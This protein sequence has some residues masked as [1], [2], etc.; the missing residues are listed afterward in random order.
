MSRFTIPREVS[1]EEMKEL[2]KKLTMEHKK[3]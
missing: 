1:I 2:F 3:L